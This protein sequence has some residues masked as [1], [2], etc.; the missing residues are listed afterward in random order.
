MNALLLA[1]LCYIGGFGQMEL[2]QGGSDARC[3]GGGGLR[4]GCYVDEEAY[5]AFECES[6][7]MENSVSLGADMLVHWQAWRVYGDLF[8]F[9]RV[10]PFFTLG[11]CGNIGSGEG[12]AGPRGGTGFFFHID[13][14]WSFRVDASA[15]LDIEGGEQMRYSIAAGFQRSF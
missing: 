13:E 14:V 8:G 7:W 9:S 4:V 11:V 5:F 15:I 10:D 6:A 1:A 12:V 3:L 2:P